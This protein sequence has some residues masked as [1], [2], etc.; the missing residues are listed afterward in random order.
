MEKDE[1]DPFVLIEKGN[2]LAA[3]SNHWAAADLYS[4]AAT[5][6]RS[7]ADNLSSLLVDD[8]VKNQERRKMRRASSVSVASKIEQA[9]QMNQPAVSS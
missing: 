2:A 9:T 7:R 3:A 1:G 4:Q 6:L 8:D 5:C